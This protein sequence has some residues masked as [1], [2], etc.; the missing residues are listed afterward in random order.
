MR[1][2]F[3]NIFDFIIK[4]TM[5]RFITILSVL[6][7]VSCASPQRALYDTAN[8]LYGQNWTYLG[9][10]AVYPDVIYSDN[11]T[12]ANITRELVLHDGLQKG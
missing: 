9:T 3:C 2:F 7:L 6:F 10:I 5:K 12:A 8:A 4:P 1:P 11:I